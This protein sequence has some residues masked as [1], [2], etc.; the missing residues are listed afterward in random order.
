MTNNRLT[1]NR[2]AIARVQSAHGLTPSGRT[3]AGPAV[4][5]ARIASRNGWTITM[6]T[7]YAL[8]VA[9]P[10]G[11]TVTA[12]YSSASNGVTFAQTS[13][14]GNR[15]QIGRRNGVTLREAVRGIIGETVNP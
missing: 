4:A 15:C 2:D 3:V 11:F 10:E 8:A 14:H 9:D 6:L 13:H 12:E 1:H 5:D 7:P